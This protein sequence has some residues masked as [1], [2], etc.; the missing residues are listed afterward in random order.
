[1]AAVKGE[2]KRF[3]NPCPKIEQARA[4]NSTLPFKDP[5]VIFHFDFSPRNFK[6]ADDL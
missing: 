1:M 6:D 3:C 5:K 2:K 4:Q